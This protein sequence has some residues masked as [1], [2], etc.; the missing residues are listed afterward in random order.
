MRLHPRH[1]PPPVPRF[2]GSYGLGEAQAG[3][4]LPG[5]AEPLCNPDNRSEGE[6]QDVFRQCRIRA[7]SRKGISHRDLEGHLPTVGGKQRQLAD[8]NGQSRN[9][10]QRLARCGSA[11]QTY[12]GC[13][14]GYTMYTEEGVGQAKEDG[15]K[16]R[17]TRK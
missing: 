6:I 10:G 7:C 1:V 11:G 8:C 17:T 2:G 9:S 4:R 14:M 13:C 5:P 12:H 3:C 16:D 15:V